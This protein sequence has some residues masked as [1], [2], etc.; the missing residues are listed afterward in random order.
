MSLKRKNAPVND[1]TELG[2][3]ERFLAS[4]DW[5]LILD[6]ERESGATVLLRAPG[7]LAE[8]GYFGEREIHE[9]ADGSTDFDPLPIP[10]GVGFERRRMLEAINRGRTGRPDTSPAFRKAQDCFGGQPLGFE[11]TEFALIP[12]ELLEAALADVSIPWSYD[13]ECAGGSVAAKVALQNCA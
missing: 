3:W 5:Q 7:H 6:Y 9:Y 2:P 10:A 13:D 4:C 8:P 11:P 12:D 1:D